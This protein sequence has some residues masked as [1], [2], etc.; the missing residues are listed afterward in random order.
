VSASGR[1]KSVGLRNLRILKRDSKL[2][3]R[4]LAEKLDCAGG[5]KFLDEGKHKGRNIYGALEGEYEAKRY[6]MRT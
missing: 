3:K 5:D 4:N 2:N 6:Q 1:L